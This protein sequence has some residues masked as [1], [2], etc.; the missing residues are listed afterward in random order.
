MYVRLPIL[1]CAVVSDAIFV[2]SR[3]GVMARPVIEGV[4]R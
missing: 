2:V 4:P 1:P 3:H